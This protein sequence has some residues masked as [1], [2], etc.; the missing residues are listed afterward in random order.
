MNPETKLPSCIVDFIVTRLIY[1]V[2]WV[3]LKII[4]QFVNIFLLVNFVYVKQ[5]IRAILAGSNC[6]SQLVV[7]LFSLFKTLVGKFANLFLHVHICY[8]LH[9]FQH[10]HILLSNN[11]LQI[12][13]K[14]SL[15]DTKILSFNSIESS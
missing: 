15:Y 9:G 8:R 1:S 5:I 3:M 10:Q 4:G 14:V 7:N 11:I 6:F 12:L 2:P 13:S